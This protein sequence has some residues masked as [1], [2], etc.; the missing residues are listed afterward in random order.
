MS[1]A[2]SAKEPTARETNDRDK[3]LDTAL[4]QIERQFG[5]GSIMKL[6]QEDLEIPWHEVQPCGSG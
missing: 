1:S 5:K 4:A 6:G 2:K 3:A